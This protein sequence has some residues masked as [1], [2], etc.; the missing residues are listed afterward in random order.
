MVLSPELKHAFQYCTFCT[1]INNTHTDCVILS[2]SSYMA[3]GEPYSRAINIFHTNLN[4]PILEPAPV[5]CGIDSECVSAF[6]SACEEFNSSRFL[7][8]EHGKEYLY[9]LVS[10]KMT[11]DFKQHSYFVQYPNL[12]MNLTYFNKHIQ[13][14]SNM[15]VMQLKNTI[16]NYIIETMN[17]RWGSFTYKTWFSV[18]YS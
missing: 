11:D 1:E 18:N 15:M 10:D 6:N 14:D 17:T 13:D 7:L 2:V 9:K 8:K 3:T 12:I 4:H 16:P 5:L